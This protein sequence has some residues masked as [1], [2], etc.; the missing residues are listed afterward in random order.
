MELKDAHLLV[1]PTSFGRQDPQLR[2]HLEA[3]TGSVQYN[4]FDR[5]M[6]AA[7]LIEVIPGIDGYIAGLDEI[8][9]SVLQ[10]AN[11][12][13]AIARDSVGVSN[14]DL[15]EAK[16]KRIIVTGTIGANSAS[17]AELTIAFILNLARSIF[18]AHFATRSGGWPRISGLSLENKVVGLIG[19]GAIGKEV[20]K[21]LQP[22]DC[23]ILAYDPAPD[24]IKAETLRVRLCTLDELIQQADFVSLHAVLTEE[25]R[26]MV[27]KAFLAAMKPGAFLINTARGEMIHDEALLDALN[28]GHLAGAALDVY[29]DEPPGEDNPLIS[30]PHILC[31]P[32]MGSHTNAAMNVMGWMAPKDCLAALKG[33]QPNNVIQGV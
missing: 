26:G 7:E 31:T 11:R 21:R 18:D 1:T 17:V 6:K 10:A 2:K 32:H 15:A 30:H 16:K 9:R 33:E 3:T 14:I 25:T 5:P 12:L 4:P 20:S 29:T 22:F 28:R 13:R 8:N 27:D 24:E 23:R 19:F